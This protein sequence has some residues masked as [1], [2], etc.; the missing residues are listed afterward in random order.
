MKNNLVLIA[1][2]STVTTI[3]GT[4][5]FHLDRQSKLAEEAAAQKRKEYMKQQVEIRT[6]REDTQKTRNILLNRYRIPASQN[7]TP[8]EKEAQERARKLNEGFR[9][10][11]NKET[12]RDTKSTSTPTPN[13]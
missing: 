12:G 9:D 1:I 10:A 4:I 6:N 5:V 2:L 13:N 3:G 11:Y 8:E 7:L